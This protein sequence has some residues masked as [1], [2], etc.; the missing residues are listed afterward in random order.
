M[1]YHYLQDYI[2]GKSHIGCV[3]DYDA[4]FKIKQPGFAGLFVY[5]RLFLTL[6]VAECFRQQPDADACAAFRRIMRFFLR[7]T[8]TCNI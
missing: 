8:R 7:H 6:P 5:I 2:Q 1:Q 4:A 3:F